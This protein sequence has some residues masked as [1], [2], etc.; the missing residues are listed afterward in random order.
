M[1][2]KYLQIIEKLKDSQCFH[3]LVNT[4]LN[5]YLTQFLNNTNLQL[6]KLQSFNKTEVDSLKK[7]MENFKND[8]QIPNQGSILGDLLENPLKNLAYQKELVDKILEEVPEAKE[9]DTTL[10]SQLGSKAF[11]EIFLQKMSLK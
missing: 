6:S 10:L 1:E 8:R 3:E 9:I 5:T 7:E 11:M 4:A 2:E